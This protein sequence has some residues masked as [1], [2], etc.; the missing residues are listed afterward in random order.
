MPIPDTEKRLIDT[1]NDIAA[2]CSHQEFN[3]WCP[4]CKARSVV[5]F[6]VDKLKVP[7]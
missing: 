7:A 2:F 3:D 6:I 5:K 1:L 4:G